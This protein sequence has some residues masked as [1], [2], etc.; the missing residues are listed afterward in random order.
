[1]LFYME[2]INEVRDKSGYIC[3]HRCVCKSYI[4]KLTYDGKSDQG[5]VSISRPFFPGMG[6]PMLKIRR[7]RDRPIF[8]MGIPILVRGHL[9]IETAPR[10]VCTSTEKIQSNCWVLH[11]VIY[12]KLLISFSY[13]VSMCFTLFDFCRAS[14]YSWGGDY[15][16]SLR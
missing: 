11:E 15:S 10:A 7:S 4:D 3:S 14:C 12:S 16:S 9:Y 8:N 2:C 13:L 5:A 1:M 6:I